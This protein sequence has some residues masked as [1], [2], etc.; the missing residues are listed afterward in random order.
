VGVIGLLLVA[1][2]LVCFH[3]KTSV[4]DPDLWLHLKAGDWIAHHHAVPFTDSFSRIASG[5]SWLAYSWLPE[6]SLYAAYRSL[7]IVGIGYFGTLLTLAVAC[8][9]LWMGWRLSGS[10]FLS[11]ALAMWACWAFLFNSMPRPVYLSMIFFSITLAILLLANRSGRVQLLYWL[12]AVFLLWS[13]SHIQFIYGLA[14]VGLFLAILIAEHLAIRFGVFPALCE[15]PRLPVGKV[16]AVLAACLIATLIGP[17]SF[18]L[19]TKIYDYSKSKIIYSLV[20]ELQALSFR[21]PRNFI[22]LALTAVAFVAVGWNKK[23]D[24]FKLALLA[25]C[26][27]VAYRTIRDSWFITIAA[28]ACIADC[29]V[30]EPETEGQKLMPRI[31]LGLAVALVCLMGLAATFG[32]D[33]NGLT[34]TVAS[35]F[36]V[37]AA[38]FVREQHLPGPIYNA[39]GWGG[40]LIWY[41]PEYPV[42][43]DGRTDL[44]GDEMVELFTKTAW[45]VSYAQ[46]PYLNGARIILVEKKIPLV[47]FLSEDPRYELLYQDKIAAVFRRR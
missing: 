34:A 40:F 5:R 21:Y 19:Y 16:A 1:L 22:Q 38:D 26:S 44:Y 2:G 15:E 25:F 29:W 11:S 41:L 12:P 18:H 17:Y 45:A 36:P 8:A 28:V 14:T 33:G 31:A 39:F 10:F 27:V 3:V 32:F 6:L 24:L 4:L 9:V 42:V 13:N 43:I 47:K 37:Q 20:I 46:D 30:K 23:V 7:G 35:A